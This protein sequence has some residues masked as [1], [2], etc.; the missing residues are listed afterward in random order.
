GREGHLLPA[1]GGLPGEGGPAQQGAAAAP[2]VADVGAGIVRPLVEPD[3]GN[4]TAVVRTELDAQLHRTGVIG[5]GIGRGRRAAPDRVGGPRG[6]ER[7]AVGGRHWSA[8]YGL[9]PADRCRIAGAVGQR[10]GRGEGGGEA[11]AVVAERAGH[12]IVGGV[13]QAEGDGGTLHR[14]VESG[15]RRRGDRHAS[16]S[17][18]WRG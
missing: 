3:A 5:R 14:L 17:G 18:D 11:G 16:C 15:R 2:E 7:P 13:L 12:R 4:G 6:Y 8:T 1:A 10:G 9:G